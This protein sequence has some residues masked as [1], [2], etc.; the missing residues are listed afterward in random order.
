MRQFYR[1]SLREHFRFFQLKFSALVLQFIIYENKKK[2]A[3]ASHPQPSSHQPPLQHSRARCPIYFCMLYHLQL[4]I[5]SISAAFLNKLTLNVD[6]F[7][8][9]K[10]ACSFTTCINEFGLSVKKKMLNTVMLSLGKLSFYYLVCVSE[11]VLVPHPVPT[12]EHLLRSVCQF[13]LI[14]AGEVAS[15]LSSDKA[16]TLRLKNVNPGAVTIET[17]PLDGQCRTPQH[18]ALMS[19]H[20]L[21]LCSSAHTFFL[22]QQSCPQ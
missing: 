12:Q 18:N 9:D 3:K 14:S 1:I 7:F 15:V 17:F 4:K 11:F 21:F 8:S 10:L 22:S 20:T 19:S 2:V 13:L 16:V 5:L 6:I